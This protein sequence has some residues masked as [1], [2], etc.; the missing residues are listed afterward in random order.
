[1]LITGKLYIKKKNQKRK[2]KKRKIYLG[3]KLF[4]YI[5]N[6]FVEYLQLSIY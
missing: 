5:Y 4:S 2:E 6:N 1:M 3:P